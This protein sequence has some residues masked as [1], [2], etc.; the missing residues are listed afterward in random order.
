MSVSAIS[1]DSDGGWMI[2]YDNRFYHV[3]KEWCEEM[4]RH[5]F[6]R[7]NSPGFNRLRYLIDQGSD[8]ADDVAA[9]FV[10]ALGQKPPPPARD[11]KADPSEFGEWMKE[12]R[13]NRN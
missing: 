1:P 12:Q 8:N 9:A 13:A 6:K 2:R 4:W 11:Q 10:E 7:G 5:Q 3:N